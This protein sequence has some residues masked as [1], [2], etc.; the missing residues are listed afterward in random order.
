MTFDAIEHKWMV[1][2]ECL[3]I[4]Q[5]VI[6]SHKVPSVMCA[7]SSI[8]VVGRFSTWNMQRMQAATSP[9][10]ST[11]L[12]IEKVFHHSPIERTGILFSTRIHA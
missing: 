11:I 6:C 12:R 10:T 3:V 7:V 1:Q 2:I 4:Y 8:R 5:E 9:S